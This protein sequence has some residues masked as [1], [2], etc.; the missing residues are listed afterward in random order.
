MTIADILQD[1][2]GQL[3]FAT[4]NGLNKFDGYRF[5][6][7]KVSPDGKSGLSTTRLVSI[8]EDKLGYIWI[9][10]YDNVVCR[11]NPKTETFEQI[12][13][14]N[15]SPYQILS[16]HVM[17]SGDVW[18]LVKGDGAVRVRTDVKTGKMNVQ[19]YAKR[20]HVLSSEKVTYPYEDTNGNLWLLTDN[21]LFLEEKGT[22]DISNLF[23]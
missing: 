9:L 11:F 4:W 10:T 7:Y 14:D 6:S 13:D 19:L 5:V 15:S 20:N 8:A 3:W 17:K 22:G 2:K 12:L 23:C 21:G 1:H 18:L 16:V